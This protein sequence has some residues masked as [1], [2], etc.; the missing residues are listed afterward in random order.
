MRQHTCRDPQP[1]FRKSS[2]ASRQHDESVESRSQRAA[3]MT[4]QPK[5]EHSE[6]PKSE[7]AIPGGRPESSERFD[8]GAEV[9]PMRSRGGTDVEA[10]G[11]RCGSEVELMWRRC[12]AEVELMWKRGGTDVEPMWSRGG[13]MWN[14]GGTDVGARW[15]QVAD[16]IRVSLPAST[17][18]SEQTKAFKTDVNLK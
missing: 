4:S 18:R 3:K 8:S 17:K 15:T 11:D 9:E 2:T 14:R 5:V 10:S 16:A 6:S 12:G 13:T 7:K 1:K